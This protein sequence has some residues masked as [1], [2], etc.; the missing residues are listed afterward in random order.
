MSSQ[1]GDFF[2]DDPMADDVDDFDFGAAPAASSGARGRGAVAGASAAFAQEGGGDWDDD[3]W[4]DEDA[5]A[6]ARPRGSMMDDE[7][8]EEAEGDGWDAE[9]W[10]DDEED[11]DVTEEYGAAAMNWKDEE[12]PSVGELFDGEV[13]EGM[14]DVPE[15]IRSSQ[16][17]S[18]KRASFDELSLLYDDF[19]VTPQ[20]RKMRE[21]AAEAVFKVER[22]DMDEIDELQVR[23][24]Q[25]ILRDRPGR[26]RFDGMEE[27]EYVVEAEGVGVRTLPDH[28]SPRTGEVL[29]QGEKFT[30]VESV[31]GEGTDR[32]LY[33]KLPD[34]RGWVF[35]DE[36]IYPGLPSVKLM[37][38]G[39]LQVSD[40]APKGPPK[41]MIAVV[42]RPNVGKSSLVNKIC[43]YSDIHGQIAYDVEGVTRDRAY[44]DG[45]HG[46]DRGDVYLFQMVDTGGLVF[47]EASEDNEISFQN[48][49]RHQIDIALREAVACIFVV[50]SQVGLT[51]D[52]RKIAKY[53]K[54]EYIS[55]GMIC[56]L[57]VSKCDRMNTMDIQTADFWQLDLG[58][59]IPICSL[60]GRGIWEVVDSIVAAGRHGL[61]P[62]R[63]KG[64]LPPMS[65]RENATSV[66]I[67]GK[68]NAGKSSLLNA[69]LG[70]ERVIVSDKAGCTTDAVDVYME[71]DDGKQY[72][73]I[74]T[75][76]I[77]RMKKIEDGT[78]W[79]AVNRAI[80]AV[81]RADVA[82]LCLD[83]AQIMS[84]TNG[85]GDAFWKPD[86]QMRYIARKTE[87]IGCSCVVVLTKWDEVSDKDEQTQRK[88]VQ[89]VRNNLAGVGQWAEIVTCSA[90][91]GQR[92]KKVLE[93]I[94]KSLAAHRKRIPTP[95]L[96]EV[97][98]DALLWK[99]PGSTGY[100]SKQ[101][102]IYYASQVST[103][104]PVIAMFCNSLK[105]FKPAYK[106]YIENKIRQ[107]LA[108]FGTPI[109]IEW[110]AR[111]ERKAVRGAEEW[112][113]HRLVDNEIWR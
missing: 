87:E 46:D 21:A 110:R 19:E 38:V 81:K 86:H 40:S 54:N 58:E 41:P 60:H 23:D 68:P 11:G 18:D 67:I 6:A 27:R 82:L 37:R 61:F 34:G 65:E 106:L 43:D 53:L 59:P 96:N 78:E 17:Q 12:A 100:S 77:R 109:Q 48:E 64:M 51:A 5:G 16:K 62:Q 47:A 71:T 9:D 66:A 92:L 80:K 73:F 89:A 90:K 99:L 32:R 103:E 36:R 29:R 70:E 33:L 49:I 2:D 93:A 45:E 72:K 111:S 63:I 15:D 24:E 91:T 75:A 26:R 104:P 55:R 35:D 44:K 112:L 30:A 22:S 107:D 28:R 74:D 83:A 14:D 7:K 76:G 3:D 50:D 8:G 13:W 105:Q 94:E 97:V 42:G 10:Q 85:L 95:V 102:R 57:A 108:W 25:G 31:D 101:G 4:E 39:G 56:T 84:D 79:L 20:Q 1:A 88:F 113:G 52:D 98:R 69:M